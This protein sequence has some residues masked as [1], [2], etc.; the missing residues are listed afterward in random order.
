MRL[1]VAL[2]KLTAQPLGGGR[3]KARDWHNFAKPGARAAGEQLE[4]LLHSASSLQQD[5]RWVGDN[6]GTASGLARDGGDWPRDWRRDHV[7]IRFA[8]VRFAP[9]QVRRM[10][11]VPTLSLSLTL[12][13]S[14]SLTLCAA[15]G[16]AARVLSP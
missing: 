16:A 2:R 10:A 12:T 8:S 1:K 9:Q 13:R 7:V 4:P 3:S 15:A 5:L 6:Q 14:P 11:G